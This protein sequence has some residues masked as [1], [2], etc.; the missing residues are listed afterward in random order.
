MSVGDNN[1]YL[2]GI[3]ATFTCEEG[4]ELTGDSTRTCQEDHTWTGT[5]PSCDGDHAMFLLLLL[6]GMLARACCM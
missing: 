1:E 3:V 6:L 2:S 4:T 5:N